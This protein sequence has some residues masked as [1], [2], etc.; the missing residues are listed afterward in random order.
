MFDR[1]HSQPAGPAAVYCPSWRRFNDIG[2]TGLLAGF[3]P[4][5]RLAS[6]LCDEALMLAGIRPNNKLHDFLTD[7]LIFFWRKTFQH[8][9]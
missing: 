4:L 7:T 3:R 9:G 8:K 6:V 5:N 1:Q 2:H